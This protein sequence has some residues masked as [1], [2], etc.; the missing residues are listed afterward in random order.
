MASTKTIR[1]T[2]KIEELPEGAMDSPEGESPKTKKLSALGSAVSA[3]GVKPSASASADV[4]VAE[5]NP[6]TS[7]ADKKALLM[8][9]FAAVNN[10]AVKYTGV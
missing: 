4:S 10:T 9:R 3:A 1:R 7:C 6:G 2:I 8:R 5:P